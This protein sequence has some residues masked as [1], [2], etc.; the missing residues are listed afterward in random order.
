MTSQENKPRAEQMISA[1][2]DRTIER[3]FINIAIGTAVGGA[4]ALVLFRSGRSRLAVTTF[5]GGWG[6]GTAWTR[7]SIDFE[8][9]DK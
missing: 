7:A 9:M 6:A 1:I 3:S 5:G 2:W 4:A 8:A